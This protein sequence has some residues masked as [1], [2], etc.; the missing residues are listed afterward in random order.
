MNPIIKYLIYLRIILYIEFKKLK[1]YAMQLTSLLLT[2]PFKIIIVV[3]MW[4]QLFKFNS[5]VFD[6]KWIVI[7]YVIVGFMEFVT[8]PYCEIAYILM[9]DIKTGNLDIH[10]VRPINYLFY[11]FLSKTHIFMIFVIG[12]IFWC[13]G[14][15]IR[16]FTFHFLM[17]LYYYLIS[18]LYIFII[19]SIVGIVSFYFDNI[20]SLRDNIWNLIKL[21]SGSII[22]LSFYPEIFSVFLNYGPFQF[23][24]YKPIMFSQNMLF[25]TGV[26]FLIS[27]VWLLIGLILLILFWKVSIKQYVSQGG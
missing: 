26:D 2:L 1:E 27:F 3:L 15:G 24:Y 13:F 9:D 20:L 19:F 17:I 23:I 21:F 8:M 11:R 5:N 25:P 14:N 22:P 6:L 10:L 7:Y 18:V 4:T 12:M 16:V